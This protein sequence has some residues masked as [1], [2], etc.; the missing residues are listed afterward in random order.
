M[1]EKFSKEELSKRKEKQLL[2]LGSACQSCSMCYLGKG[3]HNVKQMIF[4]P[5]VFSNF[6]TS[7]WVV[8]GQ[9][10]GLHE[11]LQGEP[12]VGQAGKN[13][14]NEMKK[15]GFTRDRFYITNIVKCHTPNN[16]KPTHDIIERCKYYLLMEIEILKPKL[17]ITLG[18]ASFNYLCNKTYGE[19]LGNIVHSE[20]LE[21]DVYPIYHPSPLNLA[22]KSR[23]KMF[24]DQV[25]DLCKLITAYESL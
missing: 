8:I 2:A 3:V 9:N 22:D 23:K 19:S 5:Q 11:C 10:P 12:F 14:D 13:F 6:A 4:H 24:A 15:N 18:A 16:D 21:R 20:L 1:I 25:A 17:I 7:K